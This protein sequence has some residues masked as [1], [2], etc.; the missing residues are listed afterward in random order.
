[1]YIRENDN[2]KFYFKI[3]ELETITGV[4]ANKIRYWTNKYEYLKNQLRNNSKGTHRLYHKKS[5][6]VIFKI[7]RYFNEINVKMD[8]TKINEKLENTFRKEKEVVDRLKEIKNR[9]EKIFNAP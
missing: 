2:E 6:D 4:P 5:V 3:G 9:L 8:G 1:M 7:N